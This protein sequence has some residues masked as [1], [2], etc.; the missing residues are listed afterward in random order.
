MGSVPKQRALYRLLRRRLIRGASPA[1]IRAA[2]APLM[3]VTYAVLWWL[4]RAL[5]GMTA[6]RKRSATRTT[7]SWSVIGNRI[8]G[9]SGEEGGPERNEPSPSRIPA[10]QYRV[11]AVI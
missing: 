9:Q 3:V 11:I 1:I 4:L 10:S 6:R 8:A 5:V 2:P 7:T